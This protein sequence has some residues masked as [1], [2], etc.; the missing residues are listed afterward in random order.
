VIVA[1]SREPVCPSSIL[2][3]QLKD[4]SGQSFYAR[5]RQLS[6]PPRDIYVIARVAARTIADE[7]PTHNGAGTKK[8]ITYTIDRGDFELTDRP[9]CLGVTLSRKHGKA[10]R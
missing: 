9:S 2:G 10:L 3:M 8:S 1:I 7:G 6:A 5:K 4:G